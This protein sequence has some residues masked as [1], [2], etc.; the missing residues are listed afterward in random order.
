MFPVRG[1][2]KAILLW[3]GTIV[4]ASL[5]ILLVQFLIQT[6]G[7]SIPDW[8][9]YLMWGLIVGPSAWMLSIW[10]DDQKKRQ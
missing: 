9:R 5:G 6:Y 2:S 10:Y 3:V 7:P 1:K 8:A 4:Y